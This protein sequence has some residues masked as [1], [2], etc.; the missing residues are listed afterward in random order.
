M[1]HPMPADAYDQT[2]TA[3]LAMGRQRVW[4]LMA[5]LFGDLAQAEGS[6]IDGPVLSSIM[7]EMDVR[8]E[9]VR[10]ALYRLRNDGWITSEKHGRMGRHALTPTSRTETRRA[11]KRIYASP[12]AQLDSWQLV[13][14]EDTEGSAAMIR[15]G[16]V[17]LL[18]RVYLGGATALAP[19]ECLA[20]KGATVPD[21]LHSQIAPL[22]LE[23]E[24][25]A[26]LPP[27]Q[28]AHDRLEAGQ[29]NPLQTAVLRCLLVHNWRRILLRHPALPRALLPDG[30]PGHRCHVLVDA[31]L[32]RFPRPII[33]DIVTI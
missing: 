27:L 7:A 13:L 31:L 3:L 20:L 29:L 11:S 23:A 21:W 4:S 18:P 5:T 24:Y 25:N 28:N 12:V 9:A 8:P 10:V 2:K 6:A 19:A 22:M 15:S 32:A 30:W 14:S 33:E 16:F 17:P 1:D 26:L